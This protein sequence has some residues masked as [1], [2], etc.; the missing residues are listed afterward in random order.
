MTETPY[1]PAISVNI[2]DK[3]SSTVFIETFLIASTV[4]YL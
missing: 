1:L 3:I 2:C 4:I